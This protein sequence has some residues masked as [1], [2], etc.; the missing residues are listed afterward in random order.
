MEEYRQMD[1]ARILAWLDG[2][3]FALQR[4]ERK[5]RLGRQALLKQIEDEEEEDLCLLPERQKE[6]E[7]EGER[8]KKRKKRTVPDE[9]QTRR[10]LPIINFFIN[11]TGGAGLKM[12]G[13][14][15]FPSMDER[16]IAASS[17]ELTRQLRLYGGLLISALTEGD[18]LG[19]SSSSRPSHACSPSSSL[20]RKEDRG[21]E[22]E[23]MKKIKM[24]KEKERER[25]H[26][27]NGREERETK[28]QED[29]MNALLRRREEEEEE[30]DGDSSSSFRYFSTSCGCLCSTCAAAGIVDAGL[31][32]ILKSNL[33]F[34]PYKQ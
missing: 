33:F 15:T 18:L 22:E 13:L 16:D 23:K 5:F 27:V 17:F 10:I 32:I 24:V 11:A 30:D 3:R 7:A 6:G 2:I 31:P 8:G 29:V 25:N 20:E 21:Q 4:P 28:V 12:D 14:A 34:H 19:C 9:E 1:E 26:E